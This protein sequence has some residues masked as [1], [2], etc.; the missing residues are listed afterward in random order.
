MQFIRIKSFYSYIFRT[1]PHGSKERTI[2][3][4]EEKLNNI[5]EENFVE[6]KVVEKKQEQNQ[7]G[8]IR[9][10]SYVIKLCLSCFSYFYC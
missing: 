3:R 6:K 4:K 10:L 7:L 2:E 1:I 9:K 8:P 5:S